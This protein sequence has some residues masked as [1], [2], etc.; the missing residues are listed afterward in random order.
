MRIHY[1]ASEAPRSLGAAPRSM[2]P[3]L[4]TVVD[5]VAFGTNQIRQVI[6][7]YAIT[8]PPDAQMAL[9]IRGFIATS[10]TSP[11]DGDLPLSRY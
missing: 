5:S 7:R 1:A 2:G 9:K 3:T 6:G 8:S 11:F 4:G 10:I